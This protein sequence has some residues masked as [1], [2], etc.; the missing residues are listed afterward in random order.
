[1]S[2]YML[3]NADGRQPWVYYVHFAGEIHI[4]WQNRNSDM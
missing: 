2:S 1:M 4:F 3:H